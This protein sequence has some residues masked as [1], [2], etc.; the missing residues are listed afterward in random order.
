MSGSLPIADDRCI[1]QPEKR[2]SGMHPKA[3]YKDYD[4]ALGL[5]IGFE[6]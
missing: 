6:L 5:R 4:V 2:I 3:I 1:S